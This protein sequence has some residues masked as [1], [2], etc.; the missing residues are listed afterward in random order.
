MA[1]TYSSTGNDLKLLPAT[2]LLPK[3]NKYYFAETF[4]TVFA[5]SSAVILIGLGLRMIFAL[6]VITGAFSKGLTIFTDPLVMPFTRI[7]NDAHTMV[8]ASTAATF[9]AYY[10]VYWI[11]ALVSRFLRRANVFH[12]VSRPN[13]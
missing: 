5:F 9:T 7:F 1:Q 11:I 10:F 3:V 13:N 8:Q 2:T 4:Y 12:V 6:F